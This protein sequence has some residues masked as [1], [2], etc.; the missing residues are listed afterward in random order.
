MNA[1]IVHPQNLLIFVYFYTVVTHLGKR[2]SEKIH[3]TVRVS[4]KNLEKL[5]QKKKRSTLMLMLK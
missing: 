2:S 1:T 3:I 4:K 5:K